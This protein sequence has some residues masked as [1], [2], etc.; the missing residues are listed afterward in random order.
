MQDTWFSGDRLVG[1]QDENLADDAFEHDGVY[2]IQDMDRYV[3]PEGFVWDVQ[4]AMRPAPLGVH[5]YE[6]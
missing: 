2:L 5:E 1:E 3:I 6:S 4:K